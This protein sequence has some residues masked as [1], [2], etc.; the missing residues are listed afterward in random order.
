MTNT[1]TKNV[2]QNKTAKQSISN[3]LTTQRT[4]II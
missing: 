2:E 4:N 3:V 1:E